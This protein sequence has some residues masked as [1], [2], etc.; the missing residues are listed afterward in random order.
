MSYT[1]ESVDI[2]YTHSCTPLIFRSL[3]GEIIEGGDRADN[4]FH[5][6]TFIAEINQNDDL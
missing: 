1:E 5:R 4:R 2:S 3:H 6:F